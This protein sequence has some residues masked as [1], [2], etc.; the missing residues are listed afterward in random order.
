M[1]ETPVSPAPQEQAALAPGWIRQDGGPGAEQV[2]ALAPDGQGGFVVAGLFGPEPFLQGTGLALARHRPDGTRMWSRQ[3]TTTADLRAL[4]AAVLAS[5]DVLVVGSYADSP[6]LGAGPLPPVPN[7]GSGLFLARFSPDGRTLWT[8]GFIGTLELPGGRRGYASV[9]PT[10]MTASA[11]GDLRVVG[12]FHGTV[13]FGG[14][15]RF[16]G[17][18]SL[19]DDASCPGGFAV[20]F[21]AEG[22]HQWSRAFPALPTGTWAQVRTAATDVTGHLLVGGRVSRGTD[23]GDGAVEDAG[24]FIA[25][26][27]G[28]TGALMWKRLFP[29]TDGEVVALEGLRTRDVAFNANLG[30]AFTFGGQAHEAEEPGLLR[31]YTGSLR[32]V[33]TDRWLRDLGHVTLRGLVEGTHGART[34]TGRG[35]DDTSAW[36]D[37]RFVARYSE[38]GT[39][40]GAHVFEHPP[41]NIFPAEFLLAA[42]PSDR[43]VVGATLGAPFTHGDGLYLP[44]GASDLLFFQLGP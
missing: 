23:L 28:S 39:A 10:A 4:G 26:Y 8:R 35:T 43:V 33:G 24:A 19:S 34:L 42:Q 30:G 31:G 6:D 29:G 41:Q 5:G 18:P 32:L 11:Q 22:Q 3:V 44:Q 21:S 14:G 7:S 1:P 25:R 2:H 40:L 16:A 12:H 15:P 38:T 36:G 37:T 20:S 17:E 9:I 13:D 27:H